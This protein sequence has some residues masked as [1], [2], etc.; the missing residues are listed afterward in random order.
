M[1]YMYLYYMYGIEWVA[2]HI[3]VRIPT[4]LDVYVHACMVVCV[5]YNSDY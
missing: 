1:V 2:I 5:T 4:F 3:R